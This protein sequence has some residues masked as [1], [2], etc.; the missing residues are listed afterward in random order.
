MIK[1]IIRENKK[2]F[3]ETSEASLDPLEFKKSDG[4]TRYMVV[5]PVS[6]YQKYPDELDKTIVEAPFNIGF[7]SVL[8]INMTVS[9]GPEENSKL[10]SGLWGL[11]DQKNNYFRTV[12][13]MS[14]KA[15]DLWSAIDTIKKHIAPG[16]FCSVT[17]ICIEESKPGIERRLGVEYCSLDGADLRMF[18]NYNPRDL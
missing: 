17:A 7:I 13:Y 12:A 1:I 3:N 10:M 18:V 9:Q 11:H 4:W 15:S 5:D 8:H 16:R 6:M 14:D 2:I